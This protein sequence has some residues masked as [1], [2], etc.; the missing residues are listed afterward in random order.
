[1]DSAIKM[2][3]FLLIIVII[4]LL[5][6]AISCFLKLRYVVIAYI[7]GNIILFSFLSKGGQAGG[8][9]VFFSQIPALIPSIIGVFIVQVI[10]ETLKKE[11]N[12]G[13]N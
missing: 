1:M 4:T 12:S 8:Y 6:T 3:P 10:K 9:F 11:K 2:S 7:I 5:T 13:M